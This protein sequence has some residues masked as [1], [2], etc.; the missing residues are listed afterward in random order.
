MHMLP[1][2]SASTTARH[3]TMTLRGMVTRCRQTQHQVP[4]NMLLHFGHTQVRGPSPA[5]LAVLRAL[6]CRQPQCSP[7]LL[8][9]SCQ[10]PQPLPGL[11]VVCGKQLIQGAMDAMV[12]A[13]QW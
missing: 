12:P 13:E 4:A 10:A 5:L 8:L 7:A 9:V 2:S 1:A 11:W 6:P 3:S